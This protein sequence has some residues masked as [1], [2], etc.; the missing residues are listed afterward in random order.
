[1]SEEEHLEEEVEGAVGEAPKRERETLTLDELID[2]VKKGA[3]LWHDR[4]RN[5]IRIR[6]PGGRTYSIPYDEDVWHR[7]RAAKLESKEERVVSRPERVV[8][9]LTL[10]NTWIKR[11]RPLIEELISRI[12]WFQSAVLDIGANTIL[13]MTLV[14]TEEI[15]GTAEDL[16]SKLKELKDRDKFVGYVMD[17]LINLYIAARGEAEVAALRE[18]SRELE[19]E[20]SILWE[21]YMKHRVTSD[22]LK[23]KLDLALATMCDKDLRKY[24]RILTLYSIGKSITEARMIISRGE[25]SPKAEEGEE[26]E[27]GGS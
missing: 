26:V 12:S 11:Q 2:L 19:V 7:L 18:R 21:A 20:N 14:P 8:S 17:R 9:D 3:Y 25:E 24:T 5:R 6:I 16:L 4:Q 1:M 13:L 15:P 22:E 10:W 23:R 27:S